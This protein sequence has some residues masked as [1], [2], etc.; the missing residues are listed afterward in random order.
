VP[1]KTGANPASHMQA[2]ILL[3][4]GTRA[5]YY[6]K[7]AE[8]TIT[9]LSSSRVTGTFSGKFSVPHD[10][11]NVPKTEIVITDGKFD[12]P[13][14]T[15]KVYPN[16]HSSPAMGKWYRANDVRSLRRVA[17][18]RNAGQSFLTE[19]PPCPRCFNLVAADS[20]RRT[21]L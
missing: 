5:Q 13:L 10:T 3:S 19:T 17:H 15:L 16:C 4:N 20:G 11:P 6:S 21:K 1:D 8:V 7:E 18:G 2:H 9:S 12:I 14:A